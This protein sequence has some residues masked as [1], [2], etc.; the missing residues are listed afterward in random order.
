MDYIK[1]IDKKKRCLQP[2]LLK[3][4]K[5]CNNKDFKHKVKFKKIESI[6]SNSKK[7]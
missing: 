7:T 4:F 5:I 1:K 6:R 3:Q 2:M